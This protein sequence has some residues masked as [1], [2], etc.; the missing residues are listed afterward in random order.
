MLICKLEDSLRS[1][2]LARRLGHFC[3]IV[4]FFSADFDDDDDW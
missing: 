3:Q 1:G 2:G 4:E